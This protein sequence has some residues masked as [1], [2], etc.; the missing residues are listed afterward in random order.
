MPNH[1]A[2]YHGS[3]FGKL[4]LDPCCRCL[5][6]IHFTSYRRIRPSWGMNFL[7]TNGSNSLGTLSWIT[8]SILKLSRMRSP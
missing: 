1:K 6:V 7:A 8:V 3:G 2:A 4:Q 5:L